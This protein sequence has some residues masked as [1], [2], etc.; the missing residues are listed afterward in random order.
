MERHELIYDWNR[1]G[2]PERAAVGA[3]LDDETLRD[4][5][6]SASISDPPVEDKIELLHLMVKLGIQSADIGLPGAGPQALAAVIALAKEIADKRL[7]LYPN[8]AARTVI[9]DIA[10]VVEASQA[11]G[12][13]IEASVFIG[14]SPIRKYVENWELD[15]M[16]RKVE[17]AVKF[18]VSH[19]LPVMFV[20]EDT[21]RADP[22]SLRAL[23][24]TAIDCGARRICLADTVGYA[25]PEG[26]RSLVRWARDLVAETG[27]DVKID[28]HGH[29]DRGLALINA[30][31]AIDAGVDRVHACGLGVGERCGNVAMEVLLVNMR[32]LGMIENDL[33][34]LREYCELVSRA[35]GAPVAY[36]H[37]V[38]G[39]DAFRTSTGVHAAAVM[40]AMKIG[41]AWLADRIYS[42]VPAG[43]VGRHQ[44][45]EVGPMSGASN[46]VHWLETHGYAADPDVVETILEAAKRSRRLLAEHEI[47]GILQGCAK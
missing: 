16:V 20:T 5:I 15:F 23:Y 7:P 37:P 29:N 3:E 34:S 2:A 9:A 25:T 28:W 4:G 19:N 38:I 12:I 11:A 44:E 42:S 39:A 22:E 36:N 14:S 47:R 24:K 1:L 33:S 30:L 21:T 35:C 26:T 31:V 10:P 32:M 43:W 41:D 18:G 13:P 45:I 46:V 40:K 6:Q 8:C 17:E 27:V